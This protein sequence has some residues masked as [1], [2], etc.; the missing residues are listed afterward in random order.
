M[1]SSFVTTSTET[2]VVPFTKILE[3]QSHIATA[4]DIQVADKVKMEVLGYTAEVINIIPSRGI[5]VQH[6][7]GNLRGPQGEEGKTLIYR[8]K[9]TTGTIY[10]SGDMV[11]SEYLEETLVQISGGTIPNFPSGKKAWFMCIYKHKSIDSDVIVKKEPI[12][13][14]SKPTLT[15]IGYKCSKTLNTAKWEFRYIEEEGMQATS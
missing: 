14:K 9:W 13:D 6:D 15:V 5:V 2:S 7:G 10:S 3:I 1:I 4:S 8:G 11:S 12:Y